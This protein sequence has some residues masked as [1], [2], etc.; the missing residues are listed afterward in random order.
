ML[1]A[2]QRAVSLVGTGR[3]LEEEAM[4]AEKKKV[5]REEV[6][7]I[8]WE[9]EG[10]GVSLARRFEPTTHIPCQE[11]DRPRGGELSPLKI[12]WRSVGYSK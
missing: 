1:I 4:K 11:V 7:Q 6:G 3:V 5:G 12:K 9:E 10:H 8:L 2:P